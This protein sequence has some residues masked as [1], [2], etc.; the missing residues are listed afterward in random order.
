MPIEKELPE[1]RARVD[2]LGLLFDR[3]DLRGALDWLRARS[4]EAPF[5]YVV[6][7]NVDHMLRIDADPSLRGPY[8]RA[9]L[10]LCDSRVLAGLARRSGVALPV[11]PGSDLT[12][13]LLD[14]ASAGDL[15]AIVG[16]DATLAATIVHG[17]PALRFA[18]RHPP[19]G[20]ARDAA[21]R[22]AVADWIATTG[23]RYI[24]L[25]LGSPQQEM[26]A[27]ELAER[28]GATGTAL[29]IGASLDFIAGVRSRAPRFIQRLS[30]EWAW[31]L[32][33]EP[34]RLARRYLIDAPR[35]FPLVRRWRR[36]R[37][38]P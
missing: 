18:A 8:E 9:D 30:L 4:A 15:I 20:L 12:P 37:K 26:V 19:M 36:E 31:R 17:Y 10:C 22:V 16:G 38:H 21:A 5:G 28:G 11:V 2:F 27:A 29:C 1:E 3:L 7:P 6:T 24:L 32:A 33:S 25:A 35:I 14:C 34:R 23:A 13:A